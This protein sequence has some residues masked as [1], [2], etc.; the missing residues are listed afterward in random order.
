MAG[1]QWWM[2]RTLRAMADNMM[3][4]D[5]DDHQRLRLL[6]EKAF[7]RRNVESM[8]PRLEQVTDALVDE[9]ER[10]EQREGRVDYVE[11]FAR[12]LPLIVICELLGLPEED[13]PKFRRWF[14]PIGKISSAWGFMRLLPGMWKV[15]RYLIDQIEACRH[16]PRPGLMSALVAA[17][18]AGDRLSS[19]ELLATVFLLLVAGFETTT[20]LLTIGLLTLLEH[21][22]QTARLTADWSKGGAAVDEIMRYTS[23]FQMTKPRFA[24]EDMELYGESIK[25]GQLL[26]AFIATANV[27]PQEFPDPECFDIERS[28]NRH[29]GFGK[30]IH[31]CLGLQLAKLETQIAYERLFM[32]HPHVRLAVDRET[33]LWSSRIGL[34]TVNELPILLNKS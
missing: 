17:E 2:P 9:L 4:R 28:P 10:I 5:G 11:Q 29:V 8:R 32:R 14:A 24:A 22:D 15:R 13:R 19:N 26:I 25:R 27:D 34:R 3:S 18:E 23:P 6:V 16:T 21:P 12:Q 30:G 7:R 20:H 1:M 31:T 33:L